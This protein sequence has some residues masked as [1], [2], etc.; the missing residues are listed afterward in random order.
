MPSSV[1]Q[2]FTYDRDTRILTLL[3]VSGRY[4]NYLD[5]PGW[6]YEGLKQAQSKGRYFNRYIRNQYE[7][8]PVH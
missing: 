5:V 8:E 2:R 7:F 1:I 4:Y 3:F 6:I